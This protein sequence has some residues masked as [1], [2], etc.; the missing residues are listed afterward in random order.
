MTRIRTG[1]LV[2]IGERHGGENREAGARLACK[3]NRLKK[4]KIDVIKYRQGRVFKFFFK[5]LYTRDEYI[6][7]NQQNDHF[8]QMLTQILCLSL[9]LCLQVNETVSHPK[10]SGI[11]WALWDLN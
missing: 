9:F 8:M 4:T 3:E 1:S 7:R 2:T 11:C 10:L 6:S 5:F